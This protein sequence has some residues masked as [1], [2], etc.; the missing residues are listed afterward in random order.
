VTAHARPLRRLALALAAAALVAAFAAPTPALAAPSG[1]DQ[2]LAYEKTAASDSV[3]AQARYDSAVAGLSANAS[4]RDAQ[5]HLVN[6]A[7]LLSMRAPAEHDLHIGNW[8]RDLDRANMLLT[9]CANWP[10]L[11][12]T[13]AGGDCD[14]QRRYNEV[15]AKTL[16]LPPPTPIPAGTPPPGYRYASPSPLPSGYRPPPPPQLSQPVGPNPTPTPRR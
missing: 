2:A 9:Q 12:G 6:E 7:Y 14:T 10:G 16:A 11:K 1:C 15:I 5:M 13:R 4:C 8:R 3:G